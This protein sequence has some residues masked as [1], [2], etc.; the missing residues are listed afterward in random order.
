MPARRH[1]PPTDFISLRAWIANTAPYS[2]LLNLDTAIFPDVNDFTIGEL[3]EALRYGME[4]FQNRAAESARL[5][6]ERR[7]AANNLPES[8][9]ALHGPGP[10]A[11]VPFTQDSWIEMIM[12]AKFSGDI[13]YQNCLIGLAAGIR[14]IKKEIRHLEVLRRDDRMGL[15]GDPDDWFAVGEA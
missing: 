7:D 5:Q 1:S 9:Q 6:D 8:S 2:T 14:L 13:R 12:A 4:E 15:P 3:E 11:L 10:I